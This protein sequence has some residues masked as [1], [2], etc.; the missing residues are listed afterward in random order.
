M[1]RTPRRFAVSPQVSLRQTHVPLLSGRV[2]AMDV[3]LAAPSATASAPALP[4]LEDSPKTT[5]EATPS[6]SSDEGGAKKKYA[7]S[8]LFCA[9]G[10]PVS[11]QARRT[12]LRSARA[13]LE[14]R[15]GGQEAEQRAARGRGGGGGGGRRGTR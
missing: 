3:E 8:D 12:R 2:A 14:A 1:G 15:R 5:P 13:A 9:H 6:S 11:F 7:L 10:M 4:S